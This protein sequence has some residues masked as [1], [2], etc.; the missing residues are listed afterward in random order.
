[1]FFGITGLAQFLEV[2]VLAVIIFIIGAAIP[3]PTVQRVFNV[4]AAI[5]AVLGLLQFIV[6]YIR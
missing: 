2:E 3:N 6:G 4:V 1:M 5:L